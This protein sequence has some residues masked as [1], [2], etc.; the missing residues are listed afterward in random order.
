[1][2]GTVIITEKRTGTVKRIT[3]AWTTDGAG[4]ADGQTTHVYDG[5]IEALVTVPAGGANAPTDQYDITITD[6]DGVDVLAGA[7]ANL[8]AAATQHISATNLSAV[9][10]EKLTLNVSAAG[11]VKKGTVYLYIR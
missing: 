3:W 1:M 10:N 11:A 5:K 8:A 2:A 6:Q 4:A 7:G 9:A